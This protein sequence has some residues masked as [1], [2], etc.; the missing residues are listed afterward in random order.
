[1]HAFLHT[2]A[3][4]L[5]RVARGEV[6][7]SGVDARDVAQDVVQTLLKMHAKGSF[8]PSKLENGEAYLRVVVRNAARRARMRKEQLTVDGD[9]ESLTVEVALPDEDSRDRQRHLEELK[10]RLRPR[11]AVAFAF[12]VEDGL[13]I[14]DTAKALGT[15]PNNVYQMRHRILATAQELL[16]KEAHVSRLLEGRT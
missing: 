15:N 4:F 12:L 6:A 14:D 7:G 1:M 9:L 5:L 16:G 11:D 10:G 8:V 13:S 3:A 2:H